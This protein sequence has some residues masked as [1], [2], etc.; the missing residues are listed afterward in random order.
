MMSV[1]L[2]TGL[3]FAQTKSDASDATLTLDEAVVRTLGYYPAVQ[4]SVAERDAAEASVEI[5]SADRYPTV[6]LGASL[7]QYQ[8]PM[9]VY[10]I[11]ELS[12]GSFPPF[13]R[14]LIRVGA[15]LRYN[16]YDGGARGARIDEATSRAEVQTSSLEATRQALT[17]RVVSTYLEILARR[18]TLEAQDHSL[19][20]F[21]AE[22]GRVRRLF[23]VGRAARIELLRVEATIAR[24]VAER[25]AMSSALDFA[26][27][28]LAR[29]TGVAQ[30]QLAA[31]RLVSVSLLGEN[32]QPRDELL[33]MAIQSNPSAQNARQQIE[34]AEAAQGLADSDQYPQLDA[35]A[36]YL[37][38]IHS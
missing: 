10:P 1:L 4:A 12:L 14:T 8:K 6:S 32:V 34:V 29:L 23:E 22:L 26:Q 31:S 21:R 17:A 36:Q 33:E 38:L 18:Q 7:Y 19:E 15:D 5:A 37:S 3:S 28:A 9:V 16:L 20:A 25:I 2:A 13:D 30:K 11:H 24:A 35:L 27:T